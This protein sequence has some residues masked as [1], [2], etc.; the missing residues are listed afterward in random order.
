MLVTQAYYKRQ[1]MSTA[2]AKDKA[3]PSDITFL[4]TNLSEKIPSRMKMP[5]TRNMTH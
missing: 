5:Q 1:T 2:D 4:N 3:E